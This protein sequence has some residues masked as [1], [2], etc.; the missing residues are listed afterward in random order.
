MSHENDKVK[1]AHLLDKAYLEIIPTK[2]IMDRLAHIPRHRF[3]GISCSP[4][5]GLEPTLE[6]VEKLRALPD[7]RQLRLVPHLSARMIRDKGHLR[8]VLARLEAARVECVFVPGGDRG[9]PI[10]QYS[11]SLQVLKDMAEIGHTIE[12]VGIA[13]YPEGHPFIGD[14]ELMWFLKEKQAYATYLVT[15]MCFDPQTLVSWLRDIRRAGVSLPAWIGLPGVADMSKLISLSFRIGV[16]RSIKL[17]KKQKGLLKKLITAE[18]YQ[19]DDLLAGL[20]PY[21][22]DPAI[23]VPG[24]HLY[25]FNDVERTEKWRAETF[26]KLAGKYHA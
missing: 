26:E 7:E 5:H 13:A 22:D 17:L 12:D 23:N 24:F 10:G 20:V 2:S 21:L 6:L 15:Q 18:P 16:G 1:L 8:E 11:D 19:P 25:S 14:R 4:T 3:I 9:E